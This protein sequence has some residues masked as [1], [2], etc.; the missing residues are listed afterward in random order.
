MNIKDQKNSPTDPRV[1][2]AGLCL[3]LLESYPQFR[4][5]GRNAF[6]SIVVYDNALQARTNVGKSP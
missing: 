3:L 1:L 4:V 5:E 2:F 6:I